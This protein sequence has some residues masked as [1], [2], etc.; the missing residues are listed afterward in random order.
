MPGVSGFDVVDR[1]SEE[2]IIKNQKIVLFTASTISDEDINK[3]IKKGV[4]SYLP[5]PVDIDTLLDKVESI[6][7]EN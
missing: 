6:Q 3:L 2:G 1:L 4:H 5:K 7:S